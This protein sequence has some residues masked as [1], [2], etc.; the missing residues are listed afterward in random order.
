MSPLQELCDI[1]ISMDQIASGC[2]P[3]YVKIVLGIPYL[4]KIHQET[5]LLVAPSVQV[6]QW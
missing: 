2:T 3:F 6:V 1:D 5:D 4:V